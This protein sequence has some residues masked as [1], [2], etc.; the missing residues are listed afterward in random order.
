MKRDRKETLLVESSVGSVALLF[1]DF[2]ILVTKTVYLGTS[3]NNTIEVYDNISDHPIVVIVTSAKLKIF[4]NSV[5]VTTLSSSKIYLNL[6]SDIVDA[7]RL[8]EK[9]AI[10]KSPDKDI[11]PYRLAS[12]PPKRIRNQFPTI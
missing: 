7:M 12:R 8:R 5:Q 2:G 6:H 3:C 1:K 10:E 9:S 4:K 11:N